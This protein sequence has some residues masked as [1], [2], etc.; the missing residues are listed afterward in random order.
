MVKL[1]DVLRTEQKY[2]LN[3]QETAR[4]AAL[5][6]AV[7]PPDEYSK[8]GSYMVRSLYFDTPDDTDYYEK[9]DGY[10]CR[11]KI[12]LR[13]YSADAEF[14]KLELKEKKGSLQRKRSLTVSREQAERIAAGDYEPLLEMNTKFSLEL[15]GRMQQ[16][17][18][19]PKCLVEYDRRAFMVI[20]NDTRVT[21]DS[22]L[23]ASV[24]NLDLFAEKPLFYPV[25]TDG[26]VTMEVKFNRFLLSYVKNLLSGSLGLQTSASKYGAAR[27]V[28]FGQT[29]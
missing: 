16:F 20:D 27:G 10:E 17:L 22:N 1:L 4:L 28:L 15:Y 26:M 29:E 19:R 24:S 11:R 14:A 9:L 6:S 23:R 18:Y 3:I 13:V 7:L 21:F 2:R 8:N 25:E 12:R 5:V